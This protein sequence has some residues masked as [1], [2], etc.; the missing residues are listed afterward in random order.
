METSSTLRC[1]NVW[2]FAQGSKFKAD[3][4]QKWAYVD[5][6]WVGVQP[7]NPPAILTLVD[8]WP[9]GPTRRFPLPPVPW[10]LPLRCPQLQIPCAAHAFLWKIISVVS[11]STASVQLRLNFSSSNNCRVALKIKLTDSLQSNCKF[12]LQIL[13]YYC[14]CRHSMSILVILA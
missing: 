5:M 14:R 4:A 2:N 10:P 9:T 3:F 11:I 6:N 8:I 7:P 13:K 1:R 12:Q